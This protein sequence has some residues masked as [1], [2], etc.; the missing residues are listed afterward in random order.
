MADRRPIQLG[1]HSPPPFRPQTPDPQHEATVVRQGSLKRAEN[2]IKEIFF[3]NAKVK[4]HAIDKQVQQTQERE[5]QHKAKVLTPPES[6]SIED[7]P[8]ISL[9]SRS[10]SVEA[11]DTDRIN[12]NGLGTFKGCSMQ[13]RLGKPTNPP[14][15]K[16]DRRRLSV[17]RDAIDEAAGESYGW[18]GLVEW[19][20]SN[21]K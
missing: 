20:S 18:P 19:S 5:R 6:P 14:K 21:K 4:Q 2:A 13:G 8:H 17:M 7:M 1:G 15:N 10:P 12:H 11:T 3:G 16:M 9:G